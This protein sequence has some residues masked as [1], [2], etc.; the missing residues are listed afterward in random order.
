MQKLFNLL[1]E[2]EFYLKVAITCTIFQQLFY[3]ILH[4]I[5]VNF[6][7]QVVLSYTGWLVQSHFMP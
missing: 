4:D 3:W 7:T 6:I 2:I 5:E 1:F